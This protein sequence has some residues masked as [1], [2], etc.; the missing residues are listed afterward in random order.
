[1]VELTRKQREFARREEDILSAALS[2]FDGNDWQSVTVAQIA[3]KAEIGKGTVYKHFSCKEEIYARIALSHFEKFREQ[4]PTKIPEDNRLAAVEQILRLAFQVSLDDPVG[5]KVAHFCHRA[6]VRKRLPEAVAKA[7]EELEKQDQ[8][9]FEELL[10]AGMSCG[11]I[12][13]QSVEELVIALHASFHGTLRMIWDGDIAAFKGLTPERFI[14]IN[15]R[16][17][18]AGI[19]GKRSH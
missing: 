6:E 3:N 11:E 19:L 15:S 16:F 17:M 13:R 1:M 18:V 2:L 10:E 8:C 4:W 14:E 9:F 5:A 12:P 7:F